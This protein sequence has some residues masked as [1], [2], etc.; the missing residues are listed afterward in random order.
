MSDN[1]YKIDIQHFYCLD[2]SEGERNMTLDI[3]FRDPIIILNTN[4]VVKWNHPHDSVY[5]DESEKQ[6][7][8]KNVYD[9]LVKE[10]S[11]KNI[12]LEL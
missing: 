2:Y 10:R 4:C 3:D 5:I 1:D 11:F 8:I 6:R 9:Y 12:V 7:I